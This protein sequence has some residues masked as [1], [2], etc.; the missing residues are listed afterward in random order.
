MYPSIQAYHAFVYGVDAM[1]LFQHP[2][3]TVLDVFE[4][5]IQAYG[6]SPSIVADIWND[7]NVD[8]PGAEIKHLLWTI[9][10]INNA[11]VFGSQSSLKSLFRT[12]L[13]EESIVNWISI[14]TNAIESMQNTMF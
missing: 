5:F 10:A 12:E 1:D 14:F 4:K 13:S 11:D 9:Y 6:C 7:V 3:M 2:G 8:V